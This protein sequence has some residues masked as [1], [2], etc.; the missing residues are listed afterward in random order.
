VG[1]ALT[2]VLA[3]AACSGEPETGPTV[4]YSG[5]STVPGWTT[6]TTVQLSE[7]PARLDPPTG[8]STDIFSRAV[9]EVAGIPYNVAVADTPEE[10]ALGLMFVE[11]LSPLDG[12]LFVYERERLISHWMKNTLIPLDIAF[13]DAEGRFVSKTTMVPCLDDDPEV[14]CTTYPAEGPAAFSVEVPAGGFADLPADARLVI[15]GSLD[16]SGKEI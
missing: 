12:M 8:V 13:F 6:T 5:D 16:G 4:A 9:I 2:F 10:T 15:I 3:L 11:D 14:G 1:L 7:P